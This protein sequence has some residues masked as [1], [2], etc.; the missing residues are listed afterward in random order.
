MH[1]S[2]WQS[3]FLFFLTRHFGGGKI[4]LY[5]LIKMEDKI[6]EK[7]KCFFGGSIALYSCIDCAVTECQG[8]FIV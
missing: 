1:N 7:D 5:V 3:V 6:H 2:A 8:I 4:G